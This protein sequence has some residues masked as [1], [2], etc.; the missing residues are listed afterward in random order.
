MPASLLLCFG[1]IIKEN[2]SYWS[3]VRC[4]AA[5]VALI[6]ETADE[7]VCACAGKTEAPR[8]GWGTS[9]FLPLKTMHGLKLMNCLFIE[10]SMHYFQITVDSGLLETS[11][12]ES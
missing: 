6:M 10:F 12:R 2:K 8:P 3:R 1:A 9:R 4:V 5:A 11:E 7:C